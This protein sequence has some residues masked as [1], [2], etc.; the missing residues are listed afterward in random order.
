VR[1][2]TLIVT[3]VSILLTAIAIGGLGLFAVF[4]WVVVD[5]FLIPG[6]IREQNNL[7]AAQL[8]A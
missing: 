5:A 4:V 1:H 6:W 3:L 8:G 2:L 7:L